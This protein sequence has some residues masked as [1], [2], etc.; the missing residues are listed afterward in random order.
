VKLYQPH[1]D[2]CRPHQG[3]AQA[4]PAGNEQPRSATTP[5]ERFRRSCPL[6]RV[7]RRD[8]LGGL[9]HQYELAA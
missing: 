4:I 5:S 9:I 3:I 7:Q 1:Y 6:V 2:H 8:L